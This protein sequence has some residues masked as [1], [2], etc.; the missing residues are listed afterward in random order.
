MSVK[1]QIPWAQA[2]ATNL[3]NW[4]DRVPIHK[5]SYGLE[6]FDN[7]EYISEGVRADIN[8]LMP[9][10]SGIAGHPSVPLQGL[11][12]CHLQCHIGTDTL[13]LSRFGA[14]LVVGVDFSPAAL[15]VA[16]E[17]A[18]K[19]GTAGKMAWVQGDVMKARALVTAALGDIEFDLVFTTTGTIEWLNDLN[20]WARQI[21]ALLKPGG[22]FYIHDSHPAMY[23]VDEQRPGPPVSVYPYFYGGKPIAIHEQTS[24]SGDGVLEN[25]LTY[26]YPHPISTII[27]SLIMAGLQIERMGEGRTIP[28][29]YSPIMEEVSPGNYAWPAPFRDSIPVTFTLIARKPGLPA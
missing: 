3:A 23:T 14:D 8:V 24:Y 16:S 20:L 26:T 7:P 17:L 1:N 9:F 5:Q 12:V 11:K 13:S 2:R 28:W 15:E 27:N 6:L 25:D 4:E 22:L 18:Q 21:Y 29:Q 10:L 19:H